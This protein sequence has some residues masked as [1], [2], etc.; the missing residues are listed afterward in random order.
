MSNTDKQLK[1]QPIK[2]IRKFD[3]LKEYQW[4]KGVS[5]NPKGRPKG[6]T[7]KEYAREFLMSM[8]DEAK[9]A[10][11][12]SLDGDIIWRMAEGNPAQKSDITSGGEPLPLFN[13][14]KD[15]DDPPPPVVAVVAR[16]N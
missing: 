2:P 4:Q 3:W 14:I 5:G 12:N 10:Y 15:N 1:E 11:L 7:L 8:T 6:K 13:Y 9:M 16:E